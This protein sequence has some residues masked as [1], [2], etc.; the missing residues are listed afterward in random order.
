[1]VRIGILARRNINNLIRK[2]PYWKMPIGMRMVGVPKE[3][4]SIVY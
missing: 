1:M 2:I 3:L 4:L